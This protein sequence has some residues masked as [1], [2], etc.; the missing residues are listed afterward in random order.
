[1]KLLSRSEELVL[2]A[3]LQLAGNAYGVTILEFIN[4]TL[5]MNWTLGAIYVPLDKLTRKG[6]INKYMSAPSGERGGRSKCLYELTKMGKE[7]LKEI[8]ES[9]DALWKGVDELAFD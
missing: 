1:M 3:V 2:L 7:A 8:K 4:D 6:Y 9:Q 5:K